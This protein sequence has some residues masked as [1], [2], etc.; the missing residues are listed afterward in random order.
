MINLIHAGHKSLSFDTHIEKLITNNIKHLNI[1]NKFPP[2][3]NNILY[4][5]FSK[6]KS[7]R[8]VTIKFNTSLFPIGNIY[9]VKLQK[10]KSANQ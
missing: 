1:S 5:Y 10:I 6:E 8:P 2:C 3:L 9:Y 4:L 7:K